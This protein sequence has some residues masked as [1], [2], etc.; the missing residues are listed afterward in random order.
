MFFSV[1]FITQ[2][3]LLN[4]NSIHLV[5]SVLHLATA[6]WQSWWLCHYDQG[7][8]RI[9]TTKLETQYLSD[10]RLT[11]ILEIW[12]TQYTN[13]E[14]CCS[15]DSFIP[16]FDAHPPALQEFQWP[17][18][19]KAFLQS[20]L[21]EARRSITF[22]KWTHKNLWMNRRG[23]LLDKTPGLYVALLAAV[24][25]HSTRAD[26]KEMCRWNTKT[27]VPLRFN[28]LLTI[29]E[30]IVMSISLKMLAKYFEIQIA[31]E[32]PKHTRCHL[33]QR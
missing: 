14:P 13:I 6:D 16:S 19:V 23:D 25:L 2:V 29:G 1:G 8:R 30:P 4:S 5:A 15:C 20:I 32:K 28:P 3:I 9:N 22:P 12:L 33:K 21:V 31:T 18:I 27:L 17:F 26:C 11:Q 10:Q 24:F 7:A